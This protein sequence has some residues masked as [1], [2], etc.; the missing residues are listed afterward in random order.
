MSKTRNKLM[1]LALAGA[2]AFGAYQVASSIFSDEDAA[3]TDN[4][5]NQVWIERVPENERDMIGHLLVLDH[6]R[7]KVGIVGKS[8]QWRHFIEGFK[9]ALEGDRLLTVFP[10]ERHKAKFRVKTWNCKGEAPHPF[11]LCLKVSRGDRAAVF[12]SREEWVVEPHDAA[13]SLDALQAEYPEL[14]GVDLHLGDDDAERYDA[15]DADD[16]TDEQFGYLLGD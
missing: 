2:G 11:E 9:W 8:S 5:L 12:Y 15:L 14:S 6:P 3:R 13:A 10:Q 1:A 16:V 4:L 7:A